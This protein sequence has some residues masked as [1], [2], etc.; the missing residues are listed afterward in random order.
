MIVADSFLCD[1]KL[2]DNNKKEGDFYMKLAE[3]LIDNKYNSIRA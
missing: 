1:N 3:E 2:V